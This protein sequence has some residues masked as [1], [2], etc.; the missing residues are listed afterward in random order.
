MA[1]Q[2]IHFGG[3]NLTEVDFTETDL[4]E[5]DF[6]DCNLTRA[7]FKKTNL[8]GANLYTA[9]HFNIDPELNSLKKAKFSKD[10]ITGLLK[11]YDIVVT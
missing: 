4:Q 2:K 8:K 3:S 1:L 9:V 7:S 11:K 10:N 5:A 6:S